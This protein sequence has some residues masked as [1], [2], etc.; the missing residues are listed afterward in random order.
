MRITDKNWRGLVGGSTGAE[1]CQ[2][3]PACPS[4]RGREKNVALYV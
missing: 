2:T 4:S 3:L 1:G